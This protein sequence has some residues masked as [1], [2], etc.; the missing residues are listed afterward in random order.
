MKAKRLLA[1]IIAMAMTMGMMSSLVLAD[2]SENAPEET[3][4]VE[5]TE[6]K[7]KETKEPEE[8][9]PA[10]TTKESESS[11]SEDKKPAETTEPAE[12]KK[13]EPSEPDE[14][15]PATTAAPAVGGK[16][17]GHAVPPKNDQ[18]PAAAISSVQITLDAPA[19]G[20]KPDYTAE[21]PSNANYYSEYFSNE[22]YQNYI[23]WLDVN[24]NSHMHKDSAVFESKHEYQV[25]LFLT[26]KDGYSFTT[27]TT[28]KVNG[29]NAKTSIDEDGRLRVAYNFP[30]LKP[31]KLTSVELRIDV[32]V[33]GSKPDYD[34]DF[35]TGA[36][37]YSENNNNQIYRN[38]IRWQ[39]K[40]DNVILDPDNAVF[41]T[42]HKYE[43]YIYLNAKDGYIFFE[44]TKCTLNGKEATLHYLNGDGDA[45]GIVYTFNTVL[46]EISS[47]SVTLNAPVAG[48]KPEYTA[49]LPSGANYYVETQ[50]AG[51][52]VRNG[53]KWRDMSTS[54][55]LDPDSDVFA[56]G[57]L[58]EVSFYLSAK[59]D[60][61]FSNNITVQINGQT[62]SAS[63]YFGHLL[64]CYTFPALTSVNTLSVKP[65]T[66]TVK[67]KKLK[68]KKQTVARAKVM[69]VSNAQGKVTYKLTGVKRG[70]SKKYKK[71][72][73][74]NATN[75]NV[76]IKKKLKKGTYKVTCVVKAAGDS[77]YKAGTKTVTFTIKVK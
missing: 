64:V 55:D 51:T 53:I 12:S 39:D 75:G 28:A 73:K 27:S 74:I 62:A 3:S 29:N 49:V 69:N 14:T 70:K 66:A 56:V 13:E 77:N 19:I 1:G 71:Y 36:L 33:A 65:K 31:V 54:T 18:V 8:K 7:E 23:C 59:D 15:E 21:F 10:E 52:Y 2:E 9:K 61:T 58:Y 45:L 40:T 35:P 6:P 43:V 63:L 44:N 57:H 68:K 17:D 16:E 41:E 47:V 34:A 72:F 50:S 11:E 37:Y 48:A 30:E 32:P 4:A 5:T 26:A 42:G 24:A 22:Y 46:T 38:G 67:Y 20:A 60:Y 25:I 76:T